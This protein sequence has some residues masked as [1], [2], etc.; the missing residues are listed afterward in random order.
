MIIGEIFIDY[1]H[2]DYIIKPISNNLKSKRWG[3]IKYL[4]HLL[5]LFSRFD[6]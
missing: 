5:L 6:K 2:S 4:P 3:K 1:N